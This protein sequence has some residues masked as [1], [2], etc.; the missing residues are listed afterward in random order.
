MPVAGN[1]VEVFHLLVNGGR[2]SNLG[3]HRYPSHMA[4]DNPDE[5]VRLLLEGKTAFL[6]AQGNNLAAVKDALKAQG[7]NI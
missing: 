3:K 7:I 6:Q 2:L 5:A 1:N 4:E